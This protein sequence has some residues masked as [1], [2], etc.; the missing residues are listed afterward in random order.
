MVPATTGSLL[1][2]SCRKTEAGSA[3]SNMKG[4]QIH[5]G[6]PRLAGLPATYT[7]APEEAETLTLILKDR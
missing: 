5:P 4:Y 7:E 3:I 1:W 2:R 6:K